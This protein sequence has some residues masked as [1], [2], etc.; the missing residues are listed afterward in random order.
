MICHRHLHKNKHVV[1]A[2]LSQEKLVPCIANADLGCK[3]GIIVWIDI[4]PMAAFIGSG[5]QSPFL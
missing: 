5:L 2:C 4:E 3:C 1:S